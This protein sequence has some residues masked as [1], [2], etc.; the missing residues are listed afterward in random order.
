MEEANALASRAGILAKRMLALGTT[1]HLRQ[2]YSDSYTIHLITRNAP[3]T[4]ESQM[5]ALREWVVSHLDGAVLERKSLFGQLKFSVPASSFSRS[6][7]DLVRNDGLP[8]K[9]RVLEDE[10]TEVQSSSGATPGLGHQTGRAAP[11]TIR[12]T[13]VLLEHNKDVL[14]L[15]YYSIQPS[16]LEEVFVEVISRHAVS[17]EGLE[18]RA[19]RI[20]VLR[21]RLQSWYP[22]KA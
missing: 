6:D 3:H 16:A 11:S 10:I 4:S 22:F 2:K 13:F 19:S 1:E 15:A 21:R 17:E 12:D 18:G 7:P 5:E 9:Q 20:S 8:A 14:D